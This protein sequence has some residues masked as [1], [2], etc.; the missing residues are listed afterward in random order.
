MARKKSLCRLCMVERRD[1]EASIAWLA[2]PPESTLSFT[3]KNI[4]YFNGISPS[5]EVQTLQHCENPP[6]PNGLFAFSGVALPSYFYVTLS[7]HTFQKRKLFPH[8][9]FHFSATVARNPRYATG[10]VFS[11]IVWHK[12]CWTDIAARTRPLLPYPSLFQLSRDSLCKL[13]GIL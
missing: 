9:R 1:V 2:V 4:L 5:P 7:L 6:F 10:P 8:T 12:P 13:D 3:S 11:R